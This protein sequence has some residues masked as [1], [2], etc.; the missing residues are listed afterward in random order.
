MFSANSPHFIL[1]S[2]QI[3][4]HPLS[5]LSLLPTTKTSHQQNLSTPHIY[6]D[7][8]PWVESIKLVNQLQHSSL[9]L[10]ISSGSVIKPWK[11]QLKS[12]SGSKHWFW[13]IYPT[14]S[15]SI[16]P[17]LMRTLNLAFGAYCSD[18]EYIHQRNSGV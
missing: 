3:K 12:P 5:L 14:P 17:Y 8:T 2:C 15:L 11:I 9:H 4:P 6:L 13:V 16:I 10:I 7:I 1:T 18:L